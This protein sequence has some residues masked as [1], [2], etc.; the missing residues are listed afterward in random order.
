MVNIED[1][2]R[3]ECRKII[4][5]VPLKYII[6]YEKGSD[7][8][9]VTP[10]FAR[11]LEDINKFIFSP[12][13]ANN[14]TA[15]I[16]RPLTERFIVAKEE[17]KKIGIVVKG[18]DS[19]ALIQLIQENIVTRDD[20]IVI[21][22]VCEGIID[23]R[24][25]AIKLDQLKLSR[26]IG[27]VELV[28]DDFVFNI[29]G[30][31][32]NI[33]KQDTVFEKCKFC[34]YPTP[35]IYDALIGEPKKVEKVEKLYEDIE[36][37]D[38]LPLP[39]KWQYWK[40][41]FSKCI[42]CYACKNICPLCY[43]KEC[44]AE[45]TSPVWIRSSTNLPENLHYHLMRALHLAGRCIGCEECERVCPMNIPVRALTKKLEKEVL[46]MYGYEAGIDPKAK[47]LLASF[48][49]KDPAE[50]IL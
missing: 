37:L 1:K 26:N 30:K 9:K 23:S 41:Q 20:L 17:K 21:G 39:E 43:C 27:S 4:S 12:F 50:F 18:C 36:K 29:D 10:S 31:K 3:E 7:S 46:E 14:L 35:L 13:C 40:E 5:T 32:I 16:T 48:D 25:L 28:V 42:R 22:I 2:L 49:P 8:F 6:G 47:P 44:I 45:K 33:P 19:R 34:K 38:A 11:T 15:F 24:K